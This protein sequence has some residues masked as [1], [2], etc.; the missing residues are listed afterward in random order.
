MTIN[1]IAEKAYYTALKRQ[2]NGANVDIKKY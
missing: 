1:K 2:Q